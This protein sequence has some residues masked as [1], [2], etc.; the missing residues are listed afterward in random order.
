[1]SIPVT[2]Q[3]SVQ[4]RYHS[5]TSQSETT[6]PAQSVLDVSAHYWTR[7]KRYRL[8]FH[9]GVLF[10]SLQGEDRESYQNIGVTVPIA[11]YP[12]DFVNDCDCPTFSKNAFWFQK[13]FFIR[14]V[15]TWSTNINSSGPEVFDQLLG[16]GISLGLDFGLSDL[17]TISPFIGYN[18]LHSLS[19]N[20]GHGSYLHFGV[21]LLLRND[22]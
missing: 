2:A 3:W 21:E 20:G 1:M 22:Y 11:L 7:L 14:L 6:W 17:V 5:G 4:S 18:Q 8:E 16:A 13:G 19:G 12:L 10:Q 15:P 9:P